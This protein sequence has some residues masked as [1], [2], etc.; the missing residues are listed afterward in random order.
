MSVPTSSKAL[1]II[2]A[3]VAIILVAPP[4]GVSQTP[5]FEVTVVPSAHP[6]PLTGRLVLILADE[7]RPEPRLTLAPHGPAIF[8]L[9]LGRLAPGDVAGV[10]ST[11]LGYPAELAALPPGDYY[12]QGVINVYDRVEQADGHTLWLPMTNGRVSFFTVEAG[13]LYSEPVPVSIGQGGAVRI[14]V[15]QVI[16]EEAP[17][18]DTEWLRHV[19][20]R[21]E[22]LS[23]FW[24]GPSTSTPRS[25]CPG[26]TRTTPTW[27][28]RA[29]TRWATP[30]PSPSVR[31]PRGRGTSD[32]LPNPNFFGGAWI[33][34]PDPIDFR[35]YLLID[36][37]DDA[38]AFLDSGG[39]LDGGVPLPA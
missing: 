17:P 26:A 4:G 29:C 10:D 22:R 35:S 9:D 21:S 25:C 28:I 23:T 32:G 38:N 15:V 24:G 7:V 14:T 13:N 16:P 3:L 8:G 11:T 12:A 2:V 5:R 33:L 18:E 20:I 30:S 34:Q 1:R 39:Q 31:T 27:A 19:S 6:G 37:Y 36:I